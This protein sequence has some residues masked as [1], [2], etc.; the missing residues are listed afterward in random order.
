[1]KSVLHKKKKVLRTPAQF[2]D[3]TTLQIN[4][5]NQLSTPKKE[6][7]A[8]WKESKGWPRGW[9]RALECA[10]AKSGAESLSYLPPKTGSYKVTFF[11][12]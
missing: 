12:R 11:S 4:H 2:A 6:T 5:P 3:E 10:H 9:F 1:M 7:S 8:L